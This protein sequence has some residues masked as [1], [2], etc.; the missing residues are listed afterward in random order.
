MRTRKFH[1]GTA[2]MLVNK[3]GDMIKHA[4]ASTRR[5]AWR[6]ARAQFGAY[7][8]LVFKRR[9]YKP[10]EVHFYCDERSMTSWS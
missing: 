1:L 5:L 3:H 9:G 8:C 10:I 6:H 7:A 4:P 2:F